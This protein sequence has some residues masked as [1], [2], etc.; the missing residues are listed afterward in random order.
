MR[1]LNDES[2]PDL[3]PR[4]LG[5]PL[6]LTLLLCVWIFV[7]ASLKG[8]ASQPLYWNLAQLAADR[9]SALLA[10]APLAVLA[11]LAL[12]AWLSFVRIVFRRS[13]WTARIFVLLVLAWT[14]AGVISAWPAD[15]GWVRA[16]ML[17]WSAALAALLAALF[18]E[19]SP[20]TPLP[21]RGAGS[22]GA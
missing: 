2:G 10:L 5:I 6:L 14:V 7:V 3:L 21:Q 13:L 9:G 19:Q 1:P 16:G 22:A 12:L 20:Q 8:L 18:A 11:L 4:P 15:S 17:L